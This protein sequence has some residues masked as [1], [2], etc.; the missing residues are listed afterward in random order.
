MKRTGFVCLVFVLLAGALVAPADA[1]NRK[2]KKVTRE[3]VATYD[4]PVFGFVFLDNGLC[5]PC[6]AQFETSAHERW[7]TVAVEDAVSPAPVAFLI[8][9]VDPD[10]GRHQV[11]GGGPFCGST[12]DQPVEIR[13]GYRI[14]V[15]VYSFGDVVCPGAVATTGTIT[16]LFSNVP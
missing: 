5:A 10:G 1:G 4:H 11:D 8:M 12:G 2:P 7:I 9:E 6:R 13:P 15:S 16:A 3:V 14:F